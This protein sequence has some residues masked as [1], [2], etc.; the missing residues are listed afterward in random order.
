MPY[1]RS[2]AVRSFLASVALTPAASSL[3]LVPGMSMNSA[4]VRFAGTGP[5][6]AGFVAFH[7]SQ[8]MPSGSLPE[9]LTMRHPCSLAIL[10]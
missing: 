4:M 5:L 2:R 6:T 9:V 8:A 1:S 7:C 3:R 10:N